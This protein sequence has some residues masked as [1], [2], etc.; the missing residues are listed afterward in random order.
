MVKL[1]IFDLD[2]TVLDT[3]HTIAYY[4]NFAL[5]KNGIEPIPTNEYKKLA[6]TG[7]V[8]LVKNMLNF[9]GCYSEENFNNVFHDYDTAY[10]QNTSYKTEIF[11]G[12]KEILDRLKADGKKLAVISNKPDYAVNEVVKQTY[13]DGYFEFVSG[14][15]VGYP[16]K[17]DPTLVLELI[18]NMG[19]E[20]EECV[21]VGDTSV[22]MITGK[23]AELYTIG[24][25]WGF[26]E[27]DELVENG[28]D[29]TAS[30]AI[31]LYNEITYYNR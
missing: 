11:D 29:A 2:G 5:E 20:K 23:N 17:P 7:I 8:N 4:A 12:L 19:L 22:D 3:I 13:G 1:C 18:K 9:R 15:R 14:Q 26:R 21:F 6:G 30:T 31:D 27:K 24:V 16:L 25:L 28:A 10:N